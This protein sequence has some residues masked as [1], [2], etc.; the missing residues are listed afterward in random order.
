GSSSQADSAL[1]LDHER[2][3]LAKAQADKTEMENAIRRGEIADLQT[4][5]EEWARLLT[6]FRARLLASA[7]KLAPHVNPE[8]PNL[9]RDLIEREMHEILSELSAYSADGEQSSTSDV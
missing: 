4:I 5:G 9:A 1:D 7:S 2:A 3:R 6:A 8:N